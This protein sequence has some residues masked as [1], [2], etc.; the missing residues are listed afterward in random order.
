MLITGPGYVP[1]PLLVLRSF[2][3][4]ITGLQTHEKPRFVQGK[5]KSNNV[6]PSE[7]TQ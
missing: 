5:K 6:K 7:K 1:M 2:F 3:Y 4:T